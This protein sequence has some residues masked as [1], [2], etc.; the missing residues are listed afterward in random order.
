MAQQMNL[1]RSVWA[2]KKPQI[3]GFG[4][5]Q[6]CGT[7]NEEFCGQNWGESATLKQGSLRQTTGTAHICSMAQFYGNIEDGLLELVT[8][9]ASALT[10]TE[11]TNSPNW[12]FRSVE[13]GGNGGKWGKIGENG[14]KWGKM[15][16]CYKYIMENV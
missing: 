4:M 3:M 16:S 13:M 15:G 12:D 14:G 11:L 10:T 9:Q 5:W 6:A 7:A 1:L 2:C 8:T